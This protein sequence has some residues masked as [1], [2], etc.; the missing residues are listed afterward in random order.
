MKLNS[1]IDLRRYIEENN[2]EEIY[3]FAIELSKDYLFN[4]FE[5]LTVV[6]PKLEN[7]KISLHKIKENGLILKS[8]ISYETN[9]TRLSMYTE[10][11][12][13]LH[14]YNKKYNEEKK[15]MYDRVNYLEKK[16]KENEILC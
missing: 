15:K 12:E 7:N 14:F 3:V 13:A 6:V 10:Y 4:R 1:L 11:E 2:P 8:P 9:N 16:F 5:K